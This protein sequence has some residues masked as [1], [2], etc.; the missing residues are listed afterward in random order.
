M[1]SNSAR[2]NDSK[3]PHLEKQKNFNENLANF[4]SSHA[5]SHNHFWPLNANMQCVLNGQIKSRQSAAI[6]LTCCCSNCFKCSLFSNAW[7][8]ELLSRLVKSPS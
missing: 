1:A 5:L 7:I 4:R 8:F 3:N 6:Q 2:A